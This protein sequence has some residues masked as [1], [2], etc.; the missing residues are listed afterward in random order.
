MDGK[1]INIIIIY[2]KENTYYIN[3]NIKKRVF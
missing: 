2:K 1:Y 3:I